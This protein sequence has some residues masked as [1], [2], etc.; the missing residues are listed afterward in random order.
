MLIFQRTENYVLFLIQFK[1]S[2]KDCNIVVCLAE[3]IQMN[4]WNEATEN[5]RVVDTLRIRNFGNLRE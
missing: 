3:I 4:T 1:I 5:A 2:L